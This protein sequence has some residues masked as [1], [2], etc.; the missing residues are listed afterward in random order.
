MPYI[1]LYLYLAYKIDTR[2]F[3]KYSDVN[4]LKEMDGQPL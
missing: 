1:C 2:S 4:I 3:K